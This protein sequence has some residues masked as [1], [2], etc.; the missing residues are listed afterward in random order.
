M[1][2]QFWCWTV[3]AQHR[4]WDAEAELLYRCEPA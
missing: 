3:A 1:L 2:V 4:S